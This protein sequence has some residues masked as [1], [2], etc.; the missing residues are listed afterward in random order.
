MSPS[1]IDVDD[2][3]QLHEEDDE[4]D[5]TDDEDDDTI[6]GFTFPLAQSCT[7]KAVKISAA[8]FS[9]TPSILLASSINRLNRLYSKVN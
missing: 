4:D 3:C 5:G 8:S 6:A 9:P 1:A 7:D 2:N